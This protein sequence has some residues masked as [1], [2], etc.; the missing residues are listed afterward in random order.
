MDSFV[1]EIRVLPYT[2]P[3]MDWAYCN[4]EEMSATQNQA[5]Y[6]ILGN[7]Y[8]GTVNQTFK[9]PNMAA[10]T[11]IPGAAPMGAGNG[12]NLTPR[13]LQ[14]ASVGGASVVLTTTQIPPHNHTMTEQTANAPTDIVA[15]PTANWLCHGEVSGTSTFFSF[16]PFDAGHTVSFKNPLSTT[17]TGQAHENRQPFLPMNFCICLYGIYPLRP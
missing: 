7:L 9:L 15:D 11:N 4:G 13:P 16:A 14:A 5:L 8:G 6:S 2:F 17:G 12:P 3:P 1:G 10:S